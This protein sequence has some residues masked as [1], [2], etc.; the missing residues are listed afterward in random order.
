MFIIDNKKVAIV[1]LFVYI[2]LDVPAEIKVL[3]YYN[4]N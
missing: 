2:K 3:K 4:A 1:L